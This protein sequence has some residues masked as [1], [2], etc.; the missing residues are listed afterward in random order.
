LAGS[1]AGQG[2]GASESNNRRPGDDITVGV[3]RRIFLIVTVFAVLFWI[4]F[5]QKTGALT[6]FADEQTERS[7]WGIQLTPEWFQGI[8]PALIVILSFP[9]T[10]CFARLDIWAGRPISPVTKLAWGVLLLGLGYGLLVSAEFERRGGLISPWVLFGLYFL[11]TL[12]ELCLEPI[13]QSLVSRLAPSNRRT[14]WLAVWDASS[15]FALLLA[16]Y[17]PALAIRVWADSPYSRYFPLWIGLAGSAIVGGFILW[18]WA[19]ALTRPVHRLLF[20]SATPAKPDATPT[21]EVLK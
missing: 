1:T 5:E 7:L 19:D 18:T 8:N 3:R 13:G 15:F 14:F 21:A 10:W 17:L 9:L 16:G 4:G 2:T 11:H 12:G 20:D 6:L